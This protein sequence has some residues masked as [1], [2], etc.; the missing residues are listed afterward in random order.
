MISHWQEIIGSNR[1]ILHLGDL[2]LGTREQIESLG[3][4]LP[5]KK[6]PHQGQPR[7]AITWPLPLHWL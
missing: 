3:N 5:G 7:Q 2:A 1:T 4:L 6:I